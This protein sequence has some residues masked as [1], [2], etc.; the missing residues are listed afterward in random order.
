MVEP[1]ELARLS[2]LYLFCTFPFS[3]F[4]IFLSLRLTLFCSEFCSEFTQISER[5]C[6][7]FRLQFEPI[8][9]IWVL[10]ERFFPPADDTNFGQ[11]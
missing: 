7:Y 5:F 9:L 10:M 3:P 2:F 4:L 6:A 1:E 8:T 11:R